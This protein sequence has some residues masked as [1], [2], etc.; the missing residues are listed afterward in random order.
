MNGA[1]YKERVAQT[2]VGQWLGWNMRYNINVAKH[3]E[4]V[5]QTR[6][7]QLPG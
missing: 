4:C 2:G 3:I 6:V 7:G 1:R 5:A